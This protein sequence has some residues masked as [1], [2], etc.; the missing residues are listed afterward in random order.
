MGMPD[1]SGHESKL[2]KPETVKVD[3]YGRYVVLIAGPYDW[4]V[5]GIPWFMP[6]D[7]NGEADFDAATDR[8]T[9]N[10]RRGGCVVVDPEN[11][12]PGYEYVF[13]IRNKNDRG[14]DYEGRVIWNGK[15]FE[16]PDV[17]ATW[18]ITNEHGGD[19][20]HRSPFQFD[21][22]TPT[23]SD[24]NI[25]IAEIGLHD[26]ALW[27]RAWFAR[28]AANGRTNIW[29]KELADRSE[30]QYGKPPYPGE[31][32]QLKTQWIDRGEKHA[33]YGC[34]QSSLFD[35]DYSVRLIL[36]F[37]DDHFEIVDAF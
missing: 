16:G 27:G 19:P 31:D 11:L 29:A 7:E 3:E 18:D 8:F 14:L 21:G 36:E 24:G 10:P 37:F 17:K 35:E 23:G 32:G 13:G 26:T 28:K 12:R 5:W 33:R 22:L 2:Y 1:F 15:K 25:V 30:I 34:G 4:G 20:E 6:A 9:G